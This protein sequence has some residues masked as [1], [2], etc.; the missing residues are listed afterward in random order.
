MC[1]G[2]SYGTAMMR[3]ND[4]Y[5][6]ETERLIIKSSDTDLTEQLLDYYYRNKDFFAKYE[7]E[8]GNS[9]FTP[10][11]QRALLAQE[12]RNMDNLTGAY[13]Y[14]FL[15]DDPERIIGSLSFSR[16]RR[17]PYA[18]TIFGYNIDEKCQGHGYCT[19]ACRESIDHLL[20]IVPV[21]RI[22]SRALMDNKKSIRVL[23]RLGFFYE[24]F[25]K[26]SILIG[27]EFRDH[28][29]YALLNENY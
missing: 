17:E 10:E 1:C 16:I 2:I 3:E 19:E 25:E 15:K 11:Y 6:F 12:V 4:M 23:E 7:P 26:A 13:Y 14:Y 29:R 18:S 27:G 21:H 28:N 20:S 8:R 5:V 24:G 9:Y 22:E